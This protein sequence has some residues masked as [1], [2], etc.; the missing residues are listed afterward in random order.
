MQSL[1]T[2]VLKTDP[3]LSYTVL[4]VTLG[5]V[6]MIHGVEKVGA[7]Y[8]PFIEFF[9]GYLNM[10]IFLGWMTIFI[11]IVGSALLILGLGTRIQALSMFGLFVGMIAF[12]HWDY[13]FLMNWSAQ[14]EAGQEGFEYHILV[15]SMCSGLVVGGGGKFSVD[16]ILFENS[17]P[18]H[19]TNKG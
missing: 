15:L 14:L 13:G 11:E 17:N 12:V 4:R 2:I 6:L 7:G 9:T 19:V 5:L 16:A 18:Q 8:Q 1:K 10:P 3:T